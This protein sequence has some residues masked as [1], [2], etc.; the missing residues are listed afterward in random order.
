MTSGDHLQESPG[1][2]RSHRSSMLQVGAVL[3]LLL[4]AAAV[5]A[6]S[7]HRGRML[8]Q[9]ARCLSNL[10]GVALGLFT[11]GGQS[12][13]D[14][15]IAPHAPPT[16]AEYGSV[17]YAPQKIGTHRLRHTTTADTDMSTTRNFY[18]IVLAGYV[19]NSS[20]LC[21]GSGDAVTDEPALSFLDFAGIQ[22]IS[23]GMQVPYGKYGV[24]GCDRDER[25]PLAADK[26]PFGTALELG[27]ALPGLPGA[28]PAEP[29]E[30]WRQWN[31]PNH[32]GEGQSVLFADS[33]ADW[34]RTPI[35]GIGQDN[36]YT[37]WSQ[38]DGGTADD[39]RP[40]TRGTPPSRNETPW[41]HTDALI[42]P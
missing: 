33:S 3:L 14:W 40:R 42:Y 36:I 21:P 12:G 20:F 35:I 18:T 38:A 25:L 30:T 23:Y 37:R 11:Y 26:G 34:C 16:V 27:A 4:L 24:P 6:P 29:P 22:N 10:R 5:I 39:P 41:S 19:T 9:R 15:I 32:G 17:N 2:P 31:S 1:V 8:S 28:G 7:L 13:D